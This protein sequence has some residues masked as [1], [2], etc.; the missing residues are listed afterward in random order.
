MLKT[1]VITAQFMAFVFIDFASP[2]ANNLLDDL[3]HSRPFIYI[4]SDLKPFSLSTPTA[5]MEN[6]LRPVSTAYKADA[7]REEV[8]LVEVSEQRQSAKRIQ[9]SIEKPRRPE[10]ALE[11]LKSEPDFPSLG[12]VLEYLVECNDHNLHLPSPLGSQIIN[13]LV[14][15]IVPNYWTLL[16]EESKRRGGR[17]HGKERSQLLQSLTNVSG[18][19]AIVAKLKALI[20]EGS[21]TAKQVDG[22]NIAAIMRD[23]VELLGSIL[24]N[25][26]TLSNLHR[27][28]SKA[29]SGQKQ[30]LWQEVTA[31]IGGGRVV[32]IAAEAQ[33]LVK[34]PKKTAEEPSWVSDGLKYSSWI[35][36]SLAHWARQLSIAGDD[37]GW[38]ALCALMRK[39]MRLGYSG[40][41]HRCS[42]EW[43]NC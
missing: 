26:D 27:T 14:S 25:E 31:L 7:E 9:S 15:D 5:R 23:Y 16:S 8:H 19:G 36:R 10:E 30:A 4:D 13:A 24:E 37:E 32:S 43:I 3:H 33:S 20:E 38:G 1:L 22:P 39:S 42:R 18:L 40:R 29:P 11:A 21:R 35:G 34:A 12:G 28:L 17:L 2:P 41:H 6:L